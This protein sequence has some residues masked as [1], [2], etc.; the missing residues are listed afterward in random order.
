MSNTISSG[1]DLSYLFGGTSSGKSSSLYDVLGDYS[2]LKNGSSYK[3]Y[4]AYYKKEDSDSKEAKNSIS[5]TEKNAYTTVKSAAEGLSAAAD[6][7]SSNS[8]YQKGEFKKTAKDGTQ[9]DSDYD[10]DGM[11]K[12]VSDFV[13]NYNSLVK[14]GSSESLAK[15]NDVTYRMMKNTKVNYNTLGAIGISAN[16]D[17]TLSIDR[18]KFN[19]AEVGSI[20]SLFSGSGSFADSTVSRASILKNTA[21]SKLSNSKVY[22]AEGKSDQSDSGSNTSYS[23]IV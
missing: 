10:Y 15:L 4:K 19:Q 14:N 21:V 18:D 1:N 3:L 2:S 11:Y 12:A 17:G 8:L 22:N 20:K 13:E 5:T 23:A 16:K 9:T 6:K 7:L